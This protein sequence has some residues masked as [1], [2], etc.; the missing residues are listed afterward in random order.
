MKG[1]LTIRGGY[2]R[3]EEVSF[4]RAFSI[5][6]IVL[7]HL[8]QGYIPNA[9]TIIFQGAYLGGTGAHVFFFCSGF[10]L[11]LSYLHRQT[12]YIE[13]IRRRF[14]KIYVPYIIVIIVLFF[15]PFIEVEGNRFK[16]LL[17]HVF[18]YK[19][20]VPKYYNSFGV[21]WF[22]ST[23]FQF[24]FVFI[25]LCKLKNKVGTKPFLFICFGI[26]ICWWVVTVITGMTAIMPINYFFLQY[27]WEFA[28]GMVI[29]EYLFQGNQIKI[30]NFVL[31][32]IAVGGLMLEAIFAFSD[33]TFGKIFNDIPALLGYG[34]LAL[35]LY[36]IPVIKKTLLPIDSFSYEWYLLHR[37]V[38]E[39]ITLVLSYHFAIN[40]Y[41][42]AVICLAASILLAYLYHV[43]IVSTEN[44]IKRTAK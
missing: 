11:Y 8:I 17:S 25:P 40:K 29:A 39:G 27:L 23:I 43:L 21:F 30:S 24:Y 32:I 4:L 1:T 16:V 37:A 34:A 12:N 6:T 18:L 36:Q 44:R 15:M 5:T 38:F 33:F 42:V 20:F 14:W 10:G 35:L 13:F 2:R 31:L 3:Y 26:S 7:M 22:V 41:V 28:L 19:M 9:S